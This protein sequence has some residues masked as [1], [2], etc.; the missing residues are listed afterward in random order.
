MILRI[1]FLL[2]ISARRRKRGGKRSTHI[3]GEETEGGKAYPSSFNSHD[4]SRRGKEQTELISL[5]IRKGEK[6]KRGEGRSG[7]TIETIYNREKKKM[8]EKKAVIT[9]FTTAGGGKGK[10]FSAT[11]F[12]S[13]LER[14]GK[15]GRGGKSTFRHM[16]RR[17]KKRERAL[18]SL[19]LIPLG[20]KRKKTT[21]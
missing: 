5:E 3:C 18:F 11:P 7:V 8:G 20:G 17:R 6:G 9:Y 2:D 21:R 15:E 13:R 19:A 14:Q 1:F 4:A 12:P 10:K 16:H